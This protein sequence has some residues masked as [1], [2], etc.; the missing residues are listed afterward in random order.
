MCLP[1]LLLKL[2]SARLQGKTLACCESYLTGR[3]QRVRVGSDLSAAEPLHAGVPL[4]AILS[5]LFFSLYI[6][7]VVTNADANF[8]LFADDTS[9]Y[10]TDRSPRKLQDRLQAVLDQLS[11]WFKAWGV[12]VN[13]AKSAVMLLSRKRNL[14]ALNVQL[15]GSPIPQVTTHKH[16]GVVFNSRL[17]WADHTTYIQNK[18]AKKIGLL[19]R[20]RHRLPPLVARELHLTCIPPTL[21]YACEALGRH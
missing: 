5:P 11:L 7:D 6:N 10:I 20:L 12:S 2:K 8:N 3:S 18:A 1:L 9:A 16:L 14:P 19:R 15:D 21:E 17:S 13:H 4:G